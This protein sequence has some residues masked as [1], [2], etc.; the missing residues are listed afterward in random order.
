MEQSHENNY[1]RAIKQLTVED[2]PREK[3]LSVGIEALTPSELLAILIGSGTPGESV[4]DLSQR[5]IK[6]YDGSL[7][8]MA[9]ASIDELKSQFKGVGD[10]KAVTIK[11][12]F[13]LAKLFSEE[14]YEPELIR[15]PEDAYNA[16]RFQLTSL[17]HEEFWVMYLNN[18]K[19]VIGKD[20]VAKGGITST[21]VDL[22][23]ILK[24][25]IVKGATSMILFHNHPSG[26]SRP[27]SSDDTL[28]QNIVKAASTIN[29][30]VIDHIIIHGSGFY[31]Y[32]DE[33]K[34]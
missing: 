20:C 15:S 27:S 24:N 28:T 7:R 26:T 10:A 31:S 4:V 23:L 21:T 34:I 22:R 33:G 11:A 29:I 9:M 12:A 16:M 25:A 5:M 13:Q 2:R 8:R 3:A 19:R 1:T 32:L 14:C 30:P 18:A 6:Q 17:P